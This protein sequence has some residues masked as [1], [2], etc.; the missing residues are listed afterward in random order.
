MAYANGSRAS[1]SRGA[2]ASGLNTSSVSS[3]FD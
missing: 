2:W 1:T 3:C